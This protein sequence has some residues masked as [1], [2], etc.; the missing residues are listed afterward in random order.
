MLCGAASKA[1]APEGELWWARASPQ[2]EP[3]AARQLTQLAWAG[4]RGRS[5]AHAFTARLCLRWWVNRPACWC[6]WSVTAA[7]EAG[8]EALCFTWLYTISVRISIWKREASDTEFSRG[9]E[10]WSASVL[11]IWVS[12]LLAVWGAAVGSGAVCLSGSRTCAARSWRT[13]P[14]NFT[15]IK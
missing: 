7:R 15:H 8:E 6:F 2:L 12:V 1:G 4:R 3:A 5:W 14:L 11:S 13:S 10:R 9:A